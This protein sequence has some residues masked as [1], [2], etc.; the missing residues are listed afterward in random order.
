[1]SEDGRSSPGYSVLLTR[2]LD[3]AKQLQPLSPSASPGTIS[4]RK[5]DYAL[6]HKI[7]EEVQTIIEN[8][9]KAEE[10]AELQEPQ[11]PSEDSEEESEEDKNPMTARCSAVLPVTPHLPAPLKALDFRRLLLD[12]APRHGAAAEDD[13]LRRVFAGFEDTKEGWVE[14][15]EQLL[16]DRKDWVDICQRSTDNDREPRLDQ[17]L[18]VTHK[19]LSLQPALDQGVF[20]V[21]FVLRT[22]DILK[23]IWNWVNLSKKKKW[24]TEYLDAAFQHDFS[25]LHHKR[26]IAPAGSQ[27][28]CDLDKEIKDSCKKWRRNHGHAIKERKNLALMYHNFGPAVFLDRFWDTVGS[29]ASI[30]TRRSVHFHQICEHITANLPNCEADVPLPSTILTYQRN[31]ESLY[32]IL[33]ILTGS[34]DVPEYVRTFVEENPPEEH[35]VEWRWEVNDDNT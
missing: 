30:P 17:R 23:F 9:H 27:Q 8:A 20:F 4:R 15:L 18:L 25:E 19:L 32:R 2:L 29:S 11:N 35:G 6:S 16:V 24:K 13:A 10:L 12:N 26:D 22:I 28:R 3:K 14:A 31:F 34:D 1:M 5:N 33:E 21:D 7:L